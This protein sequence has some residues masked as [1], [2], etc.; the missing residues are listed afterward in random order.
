[1]KIARRGWLLLCIL[2][3]GCAATQPTLLV[4]H[5]EREERVSFDETCAR[6]S[7]LLALCDET[8]CEFHACREVMKQLTA[9]QVVLARTGA[10]GLPGPGSSALRYWGSAQSPPKNSQPVFII[11]L[12]PRAPSRELPSQARLLEE[13][14]AKRRKPYERHHVFPQEKGLKAWFISKGI[15]IHEYTLLLELEVHRRIHQAPPQ[16]GPWNERW[17]KYQ[18]ANFGASKQE[19]LRYAG[20]LIYEFELWGPVIP[21]RKKLI[22]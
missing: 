4:E 3:T 10:T 12:G 6:D 2:L 14:E 7:T 19:I 20:Q 16:G 11:P 15:D 18:Q 22:P 5:E 9:G 1:M 8:Q 21:Y 13:L 17:R